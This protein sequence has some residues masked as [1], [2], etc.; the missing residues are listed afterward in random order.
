M[1]YTVDGRE[2]VDIVEALTFQ[3]T[4]LHDDA[5]YRIEQLRA[6][7]VALDVKNFKLNIECIKLENQLE[8]AK[9]AQE[10]A[11]QR[12]AVM[13]ASMERMKVRLK[14]AAHYEKAEAVLT[15]LMGVVS[16]IEKRM[17]DRD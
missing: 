2:F 5:A 17:H 3:N 7:R 16:E 10:R 12:Q 11:Q 1:K 6:D 15:R 13:K 4:P 8:R 9:D 14:K